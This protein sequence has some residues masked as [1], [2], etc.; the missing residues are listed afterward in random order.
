MKITDL[1]CAIIA[2]SPVL[3]IA[4]GQQS[5]GT[6]Q[7]LSTERKVVFTIPEDLAK[8]TIYQVELVNVPVQQYKVDQNV[9]QVIT[10]SSANADVETT[11]K[12]AEGS[13]ATGVAICE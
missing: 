8:E 4:G 11:G 9:E 7:Y 1:K 2:N 3:R 13:S 6:L 10:V 5:L 12:K